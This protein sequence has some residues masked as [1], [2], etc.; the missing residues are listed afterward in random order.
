ML[1]GANDSKNFKISEIKQSNYI[2][3][4]VLNKEKI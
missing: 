1:T 2:K 3:N 4:Q